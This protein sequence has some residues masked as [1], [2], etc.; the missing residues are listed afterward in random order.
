MGG[1][2]AC[3][4]CLSLHVET[5]AKVINFVGVFVNIS[6]SPQD[7]P[8]KWSEIDSG[9]WQVCTMTGH[10]DWVFSVA[11]SAAGTHV[12]SGSGSDEVK[13]WDAATGAEVS[14]HPRCT[15]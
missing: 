9:D 10:E 2:G 14:S 1:G 6:H 5:G 3:F 8:W 4:V 15:F 12:V 11:F 13:I 7:L